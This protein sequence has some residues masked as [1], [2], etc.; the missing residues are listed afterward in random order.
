MIYLLETKRLWL[1]LEPNLIQRSFSALRTT[2]G[3]E[4]VRSDFRFH[5]LLVEISCHLLSILWIVSG[6]LTFDPSIWFS[7]ERFELCLLKPW[8]VPKRTNTQETVKATSLEGAAWRRAL[9]YTSGVSRMLGRHI[10]VE[11]LIAYCPSSVLKVWRYFVG[12]AVQGHQN[13]RLLKNM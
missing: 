11:T 8:Y 9:P 10:V 2:L 12:Q 13:S 3:G 6:V 1:S 4:F 5:E 7:L